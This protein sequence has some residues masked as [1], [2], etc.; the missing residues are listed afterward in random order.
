MKQI[1]G[2]KEDPFKDESPEALAQKGYRSIQLK[3][4]PD[5]SDYEVRKIFNP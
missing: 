1:R 5:K 4:K 3:I 2:D